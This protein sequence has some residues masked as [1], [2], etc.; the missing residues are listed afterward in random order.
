MSLRR[1]STSAATRDDLAVHAARLLATDG[2]NALTATVVSRAAGCSVAQ[3]RKAFPSS[4]H[5]VVAVVRHLREERHAAVVGLAAKVTDPVA[6]FGAIAGAL[7]AWAIDHPVEATVVASRQAGETRL[8]LGPDPVRRELARLAKDAAVAGEAPEQD[9]ELLGMVVDATAL[10]LAQGCSDTLAS[11]DEVVA[12]A[13]LLATR[14]LG[15]SPAWRDR[16]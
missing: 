14:A 11:R 9:P 13:E 15:A 12:T 7:T 10:A 5:L 16:A 2:V 4:Q 3:V 1:G 6:R 8:R